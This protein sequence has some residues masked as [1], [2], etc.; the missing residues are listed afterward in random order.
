[1]GAITDKFEE[2]YRDFVTDG[3]A[4]SGA[5]NPGKAEQRILGIL[6]EAAIS[7]A[8]LGALVSVS[9]ATKAELD[10]DL[11]HDPETV[12][13]VHGDGDPANNDLYVKTGASGG[14][15][16]DNTGTLH[17]IAVELIGDAATLESRIKN[18]EVT[19]LD[20]VGESYVFGNIDD[21][22]AAVVI[23]AVGSANV[24]IN[25]PSPRDQTVREF[26]F[27]AFAAGEAR[28]RSWTRDAGTGAL[29]LVDEVTFSLTAGYNRFS[30]AL[31]VPA[32][33]FTGFVGNGVIG[34]IASGGAAYNQW[35]GGNVGTPNYIDADDNNDAIFAVKFTASDGEAADTVVTDPRIAPGRGTIKDE[36]ATGTAVVS[37][38]G[39][40]GQS[41]AAGNQ[42]AISMRQEYG[43]KG[44]ALDGAAVLDLK[45]GTIGGNERPIYGFA[46][47][48]NERRMDAGLPSNVRGDR[49][50][51]MGTNAA[52][53]R[54]VQE[55]SK[56]AAPDEYTPGITQVAAAKTF[57]DGL[58]SDFH[59]M[60]QM[61]WQ[62]IANASAGDTRA[63]FTPLVI[64]LAEDYDADSRAAVPGDYPRKTYVV[65]DG[66][67]AGGST[68]DQVWEIAMGLRDADDQSDLVEQVAPTW[69]L[70]WAEDVHA[71]AASVRR[72][73]AY[74]ARHAMMTGRQA[75]RIVDF[76]EDGNAIVLV[77]SRSLTIDT[78]LVPLQANYGFTVVDNLETPV[79]ITSVTVSD[80]KVTINLGQ[81]PSGLTWR[82]A[83]LTAA[84]MAPYTG[85]AGNLRDSSGDYDEFEGWPMHDFLLADEGTLP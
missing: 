42:A 14:G 41:N 22:E 68:I 10:A 84:G 27:I 47:Y 57:A 39:N 52:A 65:Q 83:K 9:Y 50:I 5:H 66:S 35:T 13:L 55:L 38:M 12:A 29:T 69:A 19:L 17:A 71:A 81:D 36:L 40:A 26:E 8:A 25:Q 75:L 73:G 70:D 53:G 37:Y 85:L 60:G 58:G 74:A 79:A 23:A 46:A 32:G 28:A 64:Q 82:Y 80:R 63:V 3:V 24:T 49:P 72:M 18:L 2:V 59:H 15:T 48:Y 43:A 45:A 21:I 7:N 78:N 76:Y 54:T 34:R 51:V 30:G 11:A 1:M 16:W 77:A 44:F 67:D 20:T 6:I 31:S 4:S 62:G 56:G 33:A 61:Y